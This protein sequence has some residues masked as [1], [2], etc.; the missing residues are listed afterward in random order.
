[1][2]IKK[3]QEKLKEKNID[4][5]ILFSLNEKPN[6]NIVYF[7][8]FSGVGLLAVLKNKYFLLV[9]ESEFSK[10]KNHPAYKTDKKKR[11]LDNLSQLLS[12][13]KIKKVGI[14]ELNCSVYLYKKTKK[15]IKARYTNISNIL[16]ETRMIKEGKELKYIEKACSITDD[17]FSQIIKN[18]K[19]KTEQELKK[20]IEEQII[21]KNCDLAFPPL[22]SSGKNTSNVHNDASG[23]ITKGFLMLDFGAK[24]KGYCSDMTR[25]LYVGKPSKKEVRDFNLILS[26]LDKCENAATKEKKYSTLHE[27]AVKFL[28][29]KAEFFT[30]NLGHGLGLD[31]HESP[32]LHSES[33]HKIQEN[34]PF[35]IEP[36]IYFPGQYG[37][38][39][40]DTVVIQNKKLNIL[41]KSKKKLVVIK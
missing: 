11:I 32:G 36:G 10:V 26:T 19:F 13:H 27:V 37:I 41:T 39:L 1:M 5:A 8:G 18:F 40:E 16:S 4:L 3:L 7:T 28:D 35:T 30:H 25:M 15:A 9:P 29:K 22:V 14:E 21:K 20:Y 24:F 6:T 38:R 12:R 33:K 2:R 23:K 31:I 17:I 34:I